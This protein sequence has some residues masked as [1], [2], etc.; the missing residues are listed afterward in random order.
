MS[1]TECPVQSTCEDCV[2]DKTGKVCVKF[3]DGECWQQ[4]YEDEEEECG[5][6]DVELE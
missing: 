6:G 3:Q 5:N 1:E 2:L 4:E